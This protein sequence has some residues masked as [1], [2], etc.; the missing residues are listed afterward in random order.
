M[1]MF[2]RLR[3]QSLMRRSAG[4]G[5]FDY[6]IP[7]HMRPGLPGRTVG[8]P[9]PFGRA[10]PDA[11]LN[12]FRA[13]LW[14]VAIGSAAFLQGRWCAPPPRIWH[15]RGN[16]CL[17]HTRRRGGLEEAALQYV[18]TTLRLVPSSPHWFL[19]NAGTTTWVRALVLWTGGSG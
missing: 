2:A 5:Y 1:K 14:P 9:F 18:V 3:G 13:V 6:E 12:R 11:L 16:V 8:G 7:I 10:T 4:K 19:S 15:S 17:V